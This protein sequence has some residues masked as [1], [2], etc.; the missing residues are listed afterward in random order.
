MIGCSTATSPSPFP[1]LLYTEARIY[2]IWHLLSY[3]YQVNWITPPIRC[4][5]Y[6]TWYRIPA[7]HYSHCRRRPGIYTMVNIK[8]SGPIFHARHRHNV[9]NSNSAKKVGVSSFKHLAENFPET[10]RLVLA[11][12]LSW[13]SSDRPCKTAPGVCNSSVI[14]SV[15]TVQIYNNLKESC[16]HSRS[17]NHVVYL[18]VYE[19]REMFVC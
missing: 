2:D 8:C 17:I 3:M 19:H 7:D 18:Y 10:Y 5:S 1:C 4:T 9:H 14:Y 16:A 15:V 13:L 6:I 12:Y 11:P